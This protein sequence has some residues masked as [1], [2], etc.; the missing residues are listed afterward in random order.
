MANYRLNS[1]VRTDTHKRV[2]KQLR[3]DGK[4]PAVYYFHRE[5]PV[6]LAVDLKELRAAIH[7]GAHI[8]ELHMDNK[9]HICILRDLQHN[10]VTDEITHA[11]FMGITLKEDI[12]VNIPIVITGNAIGVREFGGVLA[13]HLWEIEVKCKAS[14]IPD[15]FTI[16]VTNL[17]IGDSISVAD[18]SVENAVIL[19][20]ADTS[21]LSVVKST[22]MKLE[23]EAEAAAEELEE[24]GEGEA[25]KGEDSE[26]NE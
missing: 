21:I 17:N 10:P 1:Q 4:I 6:P 24:G 5:K 2:T 12:T 26:R 9:K 22:G 23:E 3:R 14:D 25:E 7:S 18:L 11:D 20:P 15:N 8:I 16:D 19:T 13:Q